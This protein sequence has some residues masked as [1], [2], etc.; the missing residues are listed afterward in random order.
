MSNDG[1]DF[2][3][4]ILNTNPEER[5]TISQIRN[6]TWFKQVKESQWEPGLFPTIMKMPYND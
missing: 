3:T 6:S 1:K 5:Y 4:K 2:I